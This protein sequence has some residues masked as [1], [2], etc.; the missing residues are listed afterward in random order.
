VT[1]YT[2]H[3]DDNFSSDTSCRTPK[4]VPNDGHGNRFGLCHW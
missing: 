1:E 4:V 3:V 2:I